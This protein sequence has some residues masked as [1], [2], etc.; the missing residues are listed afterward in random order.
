[1]ERRR[2]HSDGRA[3][4]RHFDVQGH[5]GARGLLPENTIPGFLLA[6]E[7]GV[8]TLETDVVISRDGEVVLSHDPWFS[9][10]FSA[11]PSGERIPKHLQYAH[12]IFEMDY[13][14]VSTYDCG[15]PNPRFPHQKVGRS[16]KPLL[17]EMIREAERFAADRGLPPVHYHVETKT[18][19]AGDQILHPEPAEFVQALVS[20]LEQEGVLERTIIQSFDPRTLRVVN[21]DD[22]PLRTSLLVARGDYLGIEADLE[23]LG[24]RPDV[25]SPD[26]RLVNERLVRDAHALGMEVI[27]WTINDPADM[28]RLR[29]LGVDGLITDYPD[30]AAEAFRSA[31]QPLS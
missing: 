6:L 14:T 19:P 17:R 24:F 26:Y 4:E 29:E 10:D 7:L 1:M 21:G 13:A 18:S 16:V 3:D 28:I 9:S 20:V 31:V 5:R 2:E 23:L 15:L 12:R 8:S 27:P 30:R 11:L 25:Y 22:V